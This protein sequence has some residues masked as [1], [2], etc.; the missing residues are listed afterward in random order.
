MAEG[1]L[2]LIFEETPHNQEYG[3]LAMEIIEI[4]CGLYK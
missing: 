2:Y 3:K 1:Q 4:W